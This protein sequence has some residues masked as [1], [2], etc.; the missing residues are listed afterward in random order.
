MK[1]GDELIRFISTDLEEDFVILS[2]QEKIIKTYTNKDHNND[3]LM[4]VALKRKFKFTEPEKTDGKLHTM[5]ATKN[6][7]QVLL[8]NDKNLYKLKVIDGTITV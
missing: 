4:N 1:D 7:D 2:K 6:E 8:F 3:G 5:V